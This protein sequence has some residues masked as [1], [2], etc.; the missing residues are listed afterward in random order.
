MDQG[1]IS[2]GKLRVPLA[3]VELELVSGNKADLL[4]L[5]MRLAEDFSLRLDFVSK[6]EKGFRA[7]LEEKPAPVKA[8]P[9]KSKSLATFD[10]AVTAIISNTLAHFV[11]IGPACAKPMSLNPFTRCGSR[12]AAC[13]AACRYSIAPCPMRALELCGM[14]PGA[15]FGI[16]PGAERGCHSHF[17]AAGPLG[18]RRLSGK[19]RRLAGHHGE[20]ANCSLC[21]GAFRDRKSC[22]DIVRSQCAEL[23]GPW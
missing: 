18:K 3:E 23:P 15:G 12:F 19:L 17:G 7:L 20:A 11:A 9:I 6:A 16:W 5:A 14:M 21:V 22:R 1:H 13:A 10:D 8:A 4:D 2:C